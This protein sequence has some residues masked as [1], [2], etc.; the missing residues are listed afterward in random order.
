MQIDREKGRGRFSASGELQPDDAV[1]LTTSA[2]AAAGVER[3]RDL[4]LDF[5]GLTL[6]RSLSVAECYSAGERLARVGRGLRR[7]AIV[8]PQHCAELH[9]FV[10]TVARNRGLHLASFPSESEALGWLAG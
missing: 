4:I 6:T 9:Q 5:T 3:L 10:L 1:E 8:A 2:L 7:V